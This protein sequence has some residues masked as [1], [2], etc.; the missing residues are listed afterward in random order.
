MGAAFLGGEMGG[1]GNHGA[2]GFDCDG[3]TGAT[4]V[5]PDDFYVPMPCPRFQILPIVIREIL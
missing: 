1:T 4:V 5:I 3:G 2:I